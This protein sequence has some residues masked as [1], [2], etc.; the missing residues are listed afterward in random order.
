MNVGL[1]YTTASVFQMLRGVIVLFTGS[2]S[3]LFLGRRLYAYHWFS[4]FLVVSGVSIVGLSGI[5][6]PVSSTQVVDSSIDPTRPFSTDEDPATLKAFIGVFFVLFAQVFGASQ[7]VIEEK[8]M[9][10]YRVKPLRAVGL[11]GIFGLLTVGVGAIILHFTIGINHPGG[12]FDIST[13][14]NQIISFKQIWITG[15]SIFF[16]IAFFNFFG[17]SVTQTLSATSRSTIDTSRIVLIWMVSLILGW[18]S[19]SWFQAIG[20][21]IYLLLN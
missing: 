7:F 8:I 19:F 5:L 17:L 15:I 14:W 13:G 16:S 20:K 9:E 10:R 6:F 3:V 4:L 1:F 18:E 2:F 21:Y 11:E 12:Y